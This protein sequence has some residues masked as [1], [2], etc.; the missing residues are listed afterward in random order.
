[1]ESHLPPPG[2]PIELTSERLHHLICSNDV[3]LPQEI[4]FIEEILGIQ[5]NGVAR[6]QTQLSL[7]PNNVDRDHL[8]S[9]L[10][11][12][13]SKAKKYAAIL[14]ILRWLPAELICEIMARTLPHTKA[15]GSHTTVLQA[16]W[17][18]GHIC[19]RWRA[20]A[21]GYLP[22]WSSFGLCASYIQVQM[23]RISSPTA[24]K[25][26]LRLTG[27]E[28]PLDV[29]LMWQ[30]FDANAPSESVPRWRSLRLNMYRNSPEDVIIP[31]LYGIKGRLPLLRTLE[32]TSS[33]QRQPASAFGDLFANLPN[34]REVYFADAEAEDIDDSLHPSIN[35]PWQQITHFRG[36][37]RALHDGFT[38]LRA[39]PN[40][41][42]CGLTIDKW[43]AEPDTAFELLAPQQ[44]ELFH[45][46]RLST[47][48]K[49]PNFLQTLTVPAL[50]ELWITFPEAA[51]LLSCIERSA[52]YQLV[53]L[54]VYQCAGDV[55][56]TL[57]PILHV[58]PALHTFFLEFPDGRDATGNIFDAL[59]IKNPSLDSSSTVHH[60]YD[61]INSICPA[62]SRIAVGD[63]TASHIT[64]FLD[65]IQSR[66]F[67]SA[68]PTPTPSNTNPIQKLTFV[69][70]YSSLYKYAWPEDAILRVERM[71]E[72]GLDIRLDSG[73][74]PVYEA[75]YMRR[76]RP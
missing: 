49:P 57:V 69:R 6:L 15:I 26:Q 75:G 12:A 53:T 72:E 71:Y 27:S 3:P 11:A 55:A 52:A 54:V 23:D 35:L 70:S 42:E 61:N 67:F 20:I 74:R 24:E 34:L 76:G 44:I 41:V 46:C 73:F 60:N 43:N 50:Q 21:L 8:E 5:R 68:H 58:L 62:L 39:A 63:L 17:W 7:L 65:M 18:L 16:P 14:S 10:Q 25:M 2:K 51:S 29:T 28:T 45:L 9:G 33:S 64:A 36:R 4:P 56:P 13:E 30:R 66:I 1:M 47:Q 31:L 19:R 40:L 48:C 37:Y 32:C 22:L 38:I 59:T